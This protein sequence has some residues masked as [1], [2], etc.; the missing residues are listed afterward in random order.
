MTGSFTPPLRTAART[1][2]ERAHYADFYADSDSPLDGPLDGRPLLVV[3]GNCQAESLRLLLDGDD[4]RTV[5]TPPVHELG[6]GDVAPL[7][8][9]L[10]R[11][12][13][14]VAQPV[15]ADYHDL[16]VGTDQLRAL[17]PP[18]ARSAVVPSVR[19]AG[20]HPWQAVVHPPGLPDPDPP[21]VPYHDVRTAVAAAW[22]RAGRDARQTEPTTADQVRAVAR[23]SV[24]E[25]RRRE[26]RAGA[27]P[28]SDLLDHPTAEAVRTVNHPGNDVLA[29]LAARVRHALGLEPRPPGTTRP[30]LTSVQAPL[31]PLVVA[32]HGLDAAPRADWEVGG[33]V[34][35]AAEVTE[36]QG[37][38][39]AARPDVLDAVLRRTSETRRLLGLA[40]PDDRDSG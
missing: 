16:P 10:A 35:T 2:A 21:V 26:Q 22:R 33:R 1:P 29:P 40:A 36:A 27:V 31:E 20:L 3:V 18:D 6:P 37:A 9:L 15:T 8:R 28:A 34:V 7:Q 12:R 23:A 39:Y 30:L 32:A 4:V 13:L 24:E 5:R 19:Y 25:L 14:L 38:W 11:T 17:L